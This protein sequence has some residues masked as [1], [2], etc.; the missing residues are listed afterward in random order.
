MCVG[1]S[2]LLRR[3][4]GKCEHLK[5][6]VDLLV[7]SGASVNDNRNPGGWTPLMSAC[8]A[9]N[10]DGVRTLLELF[11]DVDLKKVRIFKSVR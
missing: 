3:F 4:S 8:Y 10:A 5:P 2:S 7:R 9:N 1:A 6:I 11:K